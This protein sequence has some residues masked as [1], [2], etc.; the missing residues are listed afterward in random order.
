M[1]RNTLIGFVLIG[2]LLIAMFA[3]NS[4]NRLAYEGDQKRITDSIA[5]I[6]KYKADANLDKKDST[7]VDSLK[8]VA[9]SGG[10]QSGNNQE[11][12]SVVENE[13]MKVTFTNKGG[14]PKSVE[15]KKYKKFN[16]APVMLN[17]GK[18]NKI[19]YRSN[20]LFSGREFFIYRF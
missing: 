16:N 3:I 9:V 12:F 5:K 18:F 6:I 1:D 10:F 15:L 14:Q 17:E 19:S 8:S 4:K 11:L 2:A 7:K 13:V 20:V